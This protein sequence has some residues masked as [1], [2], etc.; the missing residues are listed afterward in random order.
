MVFHFLLSLG[1][2]GKLPPVLAA[3]IPNAFFGLT[4]LFLM[5]LA[6]H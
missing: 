1:Y 3:W 5:A 2:T 4:G 6:R